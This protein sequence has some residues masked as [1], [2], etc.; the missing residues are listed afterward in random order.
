MSS[1]SA[2]YSLDVSLSESVTASGHRDGALRFWGIRDKKM[3]REIK[4]LH[5]GLITS[6]AYL[7][8]GGQIITNSRDNT[9]KLIDLRTY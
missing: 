1:T 8:E 5:D 6:V 7:P 3:I 9:L 2:I 4:N